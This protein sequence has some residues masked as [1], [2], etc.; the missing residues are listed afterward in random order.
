MTKTTR[1]FS[2]DEELEQE[3]QLRNDVNASAV[4]NNFL[5]EFLAASDATEEEVLIRELTRQIEEL[6][7][8]I[9]EKEEKREELVERR[10]RVRERAEVDSEEEKH[11][12]LQKLRHVPADPEH[13]LVQDVA[14]ELDMTPEEALKEVYDE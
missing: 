5:S 7:E 11:E 9:E 6:D 10:E 3:L 4:V 2:I 8:E 12:Q 14:D 1:S 13:S